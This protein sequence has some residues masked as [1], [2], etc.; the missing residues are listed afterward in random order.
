MLGDNEIK[1]VYVCIKVYLII[2]WYIF[3]SVIDYVVC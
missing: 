3:N 2:Y 1:Y